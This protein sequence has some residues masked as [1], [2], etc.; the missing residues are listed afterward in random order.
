MLRISAWDELCSE[1]TTHELDI[2]ETTR[3]PETINLAL[4]A[5]VMNSEDGDGWEVVSH[6]MT[7]PILTIEARSD[8]RHL[9]IIVVN[10]EDQD[11]E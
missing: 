2:P 8:R 9:S 11:I 3:D 6:S 1:W 4:G 7:G 10:Y 5:S